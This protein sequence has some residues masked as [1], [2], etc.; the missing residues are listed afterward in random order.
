MLNIKFTTILIAAVIAFIIQFLLNG[1]VFGKVRKAIV[2]QKEK[3]C[4][5]SATLV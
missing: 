1:P 2:G 4:Q 3:R 5:M